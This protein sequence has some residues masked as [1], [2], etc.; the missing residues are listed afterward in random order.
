MAA[1]T[2]QSEEE[3]KVFEEQLTQLQEQLM[4][5][6]IENQAL[7]ELSPIYLRLIRMKANQALHDLYPLLF[8]LE[9]SCP[10]LFEIEDDD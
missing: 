9:E 3:K 4:M 5:V 7:R 10:F 6:M 8:E 2:W 1:V